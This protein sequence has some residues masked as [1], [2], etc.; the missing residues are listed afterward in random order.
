M[1]YIGIDANGNRMK[2]AIGDSDY[3]N[4]QSLT[5]NIGFKPKIL[6]VTVQSSNYKAIN[7]YDENIS[8]SSYRFGSGTT[9]YQDRNMGVTY[10]NGINSINSNG[11]TLNKSSSATMVI[12]YV[13]I[14]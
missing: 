2:V 12:H 1:A 3:G 11:F 8:T 13:A 9:Y 4:T 6:A 14:G 5:V 10:D 7:Y